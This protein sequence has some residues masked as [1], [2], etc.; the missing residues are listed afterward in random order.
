MS[1]IQSIGHRVELLPMDRHFE[2]IS[3]ALYCNEAEHPTYRVHTYSQKSGSPG[4]LSFI[5]D[6]M[7]VLGDLEPVDETRLRFPCGNR[8]EVAV[9]RVFLEAC[10]LETGAD[11][12]VRPLETL[13]KKSGL[14][15]TVGADEK[16]V[17]SVTATGEGKNA[18]RRVKVVAGG[19]VK[20]GEMEAIGETSVKF[21]CGSRH[22]ALAGVL[23]VRAPNVRAILRQDDAQAS[24]GVLASPSQQN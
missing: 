7:V 12:T 15:M 10:K 8:H 13:D 2:E 16:G 21:P 23:L 24:R 19:L 17:Y 20:L 1:Q 4:R 6:A 14:T 22:D 18:D 5:R 3:V 9:K 11:L